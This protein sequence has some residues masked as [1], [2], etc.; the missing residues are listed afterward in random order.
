MPA[1]RRSIWRALSIFAWPL[2]VASLRASAAALASAPLL[3]LLVAGPSTWVVAQ[4]ANNAASSNK[5]KILPNRLSMGVLGGHAGEPAR[6]VP[7][8]AQDCVQHAAFSP[9]SS[10]TSVH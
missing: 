8:A 2:S 4:P 3:A 6:I 9:P 10:G 7:S 5:G 1:S